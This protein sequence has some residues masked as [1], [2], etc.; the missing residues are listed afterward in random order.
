LS[1]FVNGSIV[2]VHG[3][4]VYECPAEGPRIARAQDAVNLIAAARS[5]G[6]TITTVPIKRLA[7]EFFQLKTCVA[8]EIVQ[9]F[10]TYGLTVAI[11]GDMRDL[12]KGSK[13][14]HD[15]VYESNQRG[16]V[17][18]LQDRQEFEERLAKSSKGG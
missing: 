16:T 14:L 4:R 11:L 12:V 7:P 2:E 6:A 5:A 13:A 15:F 17:W 8:G 10:V 9:K 1:T 18:F 3:Q